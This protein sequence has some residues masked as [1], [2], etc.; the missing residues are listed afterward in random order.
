M[1]R[2]EPAAHQLGQVLKDLV[3]FSSE[4]RK[5]KERSRIFFT[6]LAL[7]TDVSEKEEEGIIFQFCFF[8]LSTKRKKESGLTNQ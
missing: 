5:G 6:C 4:V 3:V 2:E 7:L 8:F 1:K